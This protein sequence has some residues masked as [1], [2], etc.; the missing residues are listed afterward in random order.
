MISRIF[1]G[2]AILATPPS[3]RMSAGTLSS[4]ITATAPRFLRDPRL[5]RVGYIHYYAAFNISAK[6]VFK[7][8][9]FS[10]ITVPPAKEQDKDQESRHSS[11]AVFVTQ[12]SANE[13]FA[14]T[15]DSNRAAYTNFGH[16]FPRQIHIDIQV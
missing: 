16:L 12:I 9:R 10:L 3:A 11:C 13:Y 7:R 8:I 2:G 15:G 4:A 1:L 5:L 6:P 14:A